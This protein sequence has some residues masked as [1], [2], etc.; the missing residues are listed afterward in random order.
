M[1]NLF[2]N[3][4]RKHVKAHKDDYRLVSAE[5]TIVFCEWWG[6]REHRVATL[7]FDRMH[8]SKGVIVKS[9]ARNKAFLVKG[10]IEIML[11]RSSKVQLSDGTIVELDVDF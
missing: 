5:I 3:I 1:V 7:E 4:M 8:K 9:N 11:E 2:F 6:E 10:T